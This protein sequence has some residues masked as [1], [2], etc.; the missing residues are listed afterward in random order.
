LSS[1]DLSMY[2]P[3]EEEMIQ[4]REIER[5]ATEKYNQ[6]TIFDLNMVD[7]AK[8]CTCGK[9]CDAPVGER[10]NFCCKSLWTMSDS[11]T[12]IGRSMKD[13]LT[14]LLDLPSQQP[15]T[16][17]ITDYDLFKDRFINR[18]VS[19]CASVMY[20]STMAKSRA[21]REKLEQSVEKT[22]E[23]SQLRHGSYRYFLAYMFKDLRKRI[24][25]P[26]CFVNRVRET[27]PTID[28]TGSM[29]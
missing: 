16:F 4:A 13:G 23:N 22:D 5:L 28:S 26:C 10:P 6:S 29:D 14:K 9:C 2:E 11:L 7:E 15:P 3:S 19:E 17:C 27:W 21:G 20:R 8:V 12:P 24:E 1:V 18:N 25:L